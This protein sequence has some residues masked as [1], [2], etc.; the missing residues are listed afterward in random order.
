M[1]ASFDNLKDLQFDIT[2]GTGTFGSSNANTITIQGF[3]ASV[4]VDKGGGQMFAELKVNI[5]GVSQS[6]YVVHV[7]AGSAREATVHTP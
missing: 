5:F 3:R 4:D 6:D 7:V 2:L 1:P